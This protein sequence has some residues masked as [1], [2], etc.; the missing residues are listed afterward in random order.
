MQPPP[1]F[2]FWGTR[3]VFFIPV[4]TLPDSRRWI[5]MIALLTG[6]AGPGPVAAA[7]AAEGGVPCT[8]VSRHYGGPKTGTYVLGPIAP[9]NLIVQA[10]SVSLDRA[11]VEAAVHAALSARGFRRV[12]SRDEAQ[13]VIAI[14][15]GR[16]EYPPPFEFMGI[17]PMHTPFHQW[18][19]ALK[20]FDQSHNNLDYEDLQARRPSQ[21]A[22]AKF[23]LLVVAALDARLLREKQEQKLRWETRIT[24]PAE[25]GDFETLLEP[26][27]AAG[28]AQFGTN[29][30][31]GVRTTITPIVRPAAVAAQP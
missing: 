20:E 14:G 10:E 1:A 24:T 6:F 9:A 31:S 5:L 26:M 21:L 4:K 2:S 30:R 13:L 23:N 11:A 19:T 12:L 15:Y 17:D 7:A 8:T 22:R 16:G 25:E 29:R 3:V 28:A 27:I 18:P